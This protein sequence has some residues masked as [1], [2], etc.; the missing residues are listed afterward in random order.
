MQR[1]TLVLYYI[2]LWCGKI[3]WGIFMVPIQQL[4]GWTEVV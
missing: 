2:L 4:S 3:G 1:M